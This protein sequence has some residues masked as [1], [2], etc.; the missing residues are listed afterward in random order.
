MYTH[1][2]GLRATV[3]GAAVLAGACVSG[4]GP[5]SSVMIAPEST[6][7]TLNRP[8]P[9]PLADAPRIS[10]TEL[11]VIVEGWPGE[12]AV[13]PSLGLQELVAAGL[14][15][16]RDVEFV[17]RRRFVAAVEREARGLP[18][19][20]HSPPPGVSPG[21]EFQLAGSW[22]PAG[23]SATLALR[24][25]DVE[26][27]GV[28]TAWRVTT[29]QGVDPTGLAR[30]V[31]GS[32]VT[33]LRGLGRLAV[34]SDPLQSRVD[35]APSTVT[36]SGVTAE[37]VAAFFRGIAAEDRFDWEAARRAFQRAMEIEGDAFFE[38]DVAL[39]RVA[40]LR[41]GGTLGAGDD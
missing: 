8:R 2:T 29:P 7:R 4:G 40:R 35:P 39:G 1:S 33:A 37:A 16:R 36:P 19:L 3:L 32:T 24:L 11:A 25:V 18:P 17:E 34:W 14:I 26:T 5:P 12:S 27:G 9:Q 22:I 21:A 38:P 31:V 41:A 6:W 23:D 10:V 30:V 15:R 13:P 20:P 28:V